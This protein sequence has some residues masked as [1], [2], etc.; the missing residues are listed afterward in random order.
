[1]YNKK[2]VNIEVEE[3]KLIPSFSQTKTAF[4]NGKKIKK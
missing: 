1:M 4:F 3:T 2:N